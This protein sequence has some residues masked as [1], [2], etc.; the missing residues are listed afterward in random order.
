MFDFETYRPQLVALCRQHGV[1][2]LDLF[3]SAA[4][5]GFDPARSDIDFIVEFSPEAAPAIFQH[6]FALKASLEALLERSV[7]LVMAGAMRNPYFIDSVRKTR[8]PI[9]ASAHAQAA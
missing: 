3:G 6:Y 9:Y 4:G 2:R 8:R 7:D 5:D 1:D